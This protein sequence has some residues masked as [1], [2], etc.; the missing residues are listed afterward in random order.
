VHEQHILVGGQ[1]RSDKIG[2]LGNSRREQPVMNALVLFGGKN[3]GPDG[4]VIV[5][6]VDELEGQH[7]ALSIQ[8]SSG[9]AENSLIIR[10][11]PRF[12]RTS[13][14]VRYSSFAIRGAIIALGFESAI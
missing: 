11:Y 10:D 8:H 4:Q 6:A 2:R 13:F 7:A 5:V 12:G 14:A 1:T 3:M 9:G